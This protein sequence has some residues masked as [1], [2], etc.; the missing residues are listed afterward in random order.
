MI[1]RDE[2]RKIPSNF[3]LFV[4]DGQRQFLSLDIESSYRVK[5]AIRYDILHT[6]CP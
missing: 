6:H 2:R 4:T 5:R 1:L 3:T